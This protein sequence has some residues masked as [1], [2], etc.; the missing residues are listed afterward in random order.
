MQSLQ[1]DNDKA[2]DRCPLSPDIVESIRMMIKMGF[3]RNA[4]EIVYR[5]HVM[6]MHKKRGQ[7]KTIWG[8]LRGALLGACGARKKKVR[9]NKLD[10]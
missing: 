7:P 6:T 9:R 8:R 1:L 5:H 10:G 3:M 4:I 2:D